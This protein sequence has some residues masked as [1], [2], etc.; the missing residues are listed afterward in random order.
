LLCVQG[1]PVFCLPSPSKNPPFFRTRMFRIGFI[2][3]SVVMMW[4]TLSYWTYWAHFP[5][6]GNDFA[7]LRISKSFPPIPVQL[8]LFIL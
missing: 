2:G 1:R 5:I 3:C 6:M 8:N 4:N 7:D